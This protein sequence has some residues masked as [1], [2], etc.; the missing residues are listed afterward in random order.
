M[1]LRILFIVGCTVGIALFLTYFILDFE[2]NQRWLWFDR[3]NNFL[4]DYMNVVNGYSEKAYFPLSY[5]L[6]YFLSCMADYKQLPPLEA[7]Y[8]QI[9]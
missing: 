7:G 5:V 6:F 4:G 2:G 1:T 3:G 9:G 8:T